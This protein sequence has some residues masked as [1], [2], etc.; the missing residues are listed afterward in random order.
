MFK[1]ETFVHYVIFIVRS[2]SLL[3]VVFP[4]IKTLYSAV[5]RGKK[6]RIS[7]IKKKKNSNSYTEI[8]HHGTKIGI[9]KKLNNRDYSYNN[10]YTRVAKEKREKKARCYLGGGRGTFA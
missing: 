9:K 10:N 1:T 8:R 3:E 7:L 2:A 6:K 5:T 4:G